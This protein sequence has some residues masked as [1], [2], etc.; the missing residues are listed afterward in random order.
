MV[1]TAVAPAPGDQEPA[2]I[3]A[4]GRIF[5]VLFSPGETFKDIVR[6]PSWFAPLVI[7]TV[8]SIGVC[9][10]LVQ[11]VDWANMIRK[12]QDASPRSA[13]MT[14]EQK[15]TAVNVGV[16][17]AV[18]IA[19]AAG[20]VG[21]VI[22]ALLFAVIYMLAFN[23]FKGAGLKFGTSFAIMCYAFVPSILLSILAIIVLYFKRFGEV[24]PQHMTAT[25]VGAFSGR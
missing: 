4:V 15:E 10:L 13:Q 6:K 1:T 16:K 25:N 19:W 18:P 9:A 24:D 3:G 23:M 20:F 7:L 14:D 5:G 17:I 12:Q 22:G 8:L 21:P 2:K 11:K